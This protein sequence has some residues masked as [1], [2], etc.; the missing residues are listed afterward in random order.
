LK[1]NGSI[2]VVLRFRGAGANA[3]DGF[4]MTGDEPAQRNRIVVQKIADND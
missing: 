2:L 1:F 4:H 3:S